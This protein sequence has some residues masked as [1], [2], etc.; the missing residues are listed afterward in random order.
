MSNSFRAN[1]M[2]PQER[3]RAARSDAGFSILE[4]VLA[5]AVLTMAAIGTLQLS[6]ATVGLEAQSRETAVA[7]SIC[8]KVI[9]DMKAVPFSEIFERYNGTTEDDP[10]TAES[11]GGAFTVNASWVGGPP[12]DF[13]VVINFPVNADGALSEESA[14]LVPGFPTDLNVDGALTVDADLVGYRV[15]P[16]LLDVSWASASGQTK[17][18]RIPLIFS[19]RGIDE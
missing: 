12:V 17:T 3:R 4:L 16:A 1:T 9:E 2:R 14:A 19:D 13:D 15:L 7:T 10:P 18:Q 11:P 8:R 5:V 6:V